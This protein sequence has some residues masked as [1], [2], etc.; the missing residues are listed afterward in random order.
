MV[1]EVLGDLALPYRVQ[2]MFEPYHP[3]GMWGITFVDPTTPGGRHQ[4]QIVVG[5]VEEA[6][7]GDTKAE[8]AERLL[9]H[10]P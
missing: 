6:R 4:F 10:A 5:P 8:L 9:A 2:N 7:L 1:H 3:A